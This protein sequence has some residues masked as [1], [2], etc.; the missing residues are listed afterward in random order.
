[1]E[2]WDRDRLNKRPNK[3]ECGLQREKEARGQR[4]KKGLAELPNMII[5]KYH[6]M[7]SNAKWKGNDPLMGETVGQIHHCTP[8]ESYALVVLFSIWA[9]LFPWFCI[10]VW[11][12]I[13]LPHFCSSSDN[14]PSSYPLQIGLCKL[15]SLHVTPK[16]VFLAPHRKAVW[17]RWNGHGAV[18]SKEH[19]EA[20]PQSIG[21][22]RVTKGSWDRHRC[23]FS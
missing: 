14:G 10:P 6:G 18:L 1:M 19:H 22:V 20:R 13:Y 3:E 2:P 9:A 23:L 5:Q 4:T 17:A 15:S 7:C 21:H 8:C 11:A 12:A 16:L